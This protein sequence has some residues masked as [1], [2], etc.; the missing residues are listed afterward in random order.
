LGLKGAIASLALLQD[1]AKLAQSSDT[2]IHHR[3]HT[4]EKKKN[5]GKTGFIN[6]RKLDMPPFLLTLLF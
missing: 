4:R 3:Q 2:V 6:P 5:Q 1:E